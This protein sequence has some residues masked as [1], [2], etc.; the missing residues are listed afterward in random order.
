MNFSFLFLLQ[1]YCPSQFILLG[2]HRG[3]RRSEFSHSCP[4]SFLASLAV[5]HKTLD[6]TFSLFVNISKETNCR[7]SKGT[8]SFSILSSMG[9]S[10]KTYPSQSHPDELLFR[11]PTQ[12][13]VCLT[14]GLMRKSINSH[15]HITST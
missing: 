10:L 9:C 15:F 4:V 12:R 1:C 11:A 6:M 13:Y 5:S 8:W 2:L 3:I 7:H 14:S